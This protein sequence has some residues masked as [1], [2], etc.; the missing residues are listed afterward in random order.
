VSSA[1]SDVGVCLIV[2]DR[3][4]DLQQ[5]VAIGGT[6][7]QSSSKVSGHEIE[8]GIRLQGV[9]KGAPAPIVSGSDQQIILPADPI[10]EQ[11]VGN[12]LQVLAV[13]ICLQDCCFALGGNLI[14]GDGTV[15]VGVVTDGRFLKSTNVVWHRFGRCGAS[16][17]RF[18]NWY[19][20]LI[21]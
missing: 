11:V 9:F 4:Q 21:L 12:C 14:D 5:F 6:V 1:V 3:I 20:L 7:Q 18:G 15:G 10:R 2:G 16:G 13:L 17:G 8:R 19:T